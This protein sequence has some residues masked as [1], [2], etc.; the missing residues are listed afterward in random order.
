MQIF[1][2][3]TQA[4]VVSLL[5]ACDLPTADLEPHHFEHFFGCGPVDAPAAIGGVEI[6]GQVALLRS[7]AVTTEARGTG[8][9]RRMVA[10]L[11]RHA[12][13]QGVRELYLLTTTAERFFAALGYCEADRHKAPEAIRSTR[14]FAGLCP[15][16]AAFMMKR[17]AD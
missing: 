11:E 10:E 8:C 7:L 3:P 16:S 12:Q 9:G 5:A 6:H 13:A 2:C 17:L 1:Q 15:D 4:S 14:E